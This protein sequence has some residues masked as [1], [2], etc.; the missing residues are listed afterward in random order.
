MSVFGVSFTVYTLVIVAIGI[1]S[2][3]YARRS[4][5]DFF[6]AGRSL[7]PWVAALSASASSESGWVTLGLVGWAFTSGVQA[8]W[9]I[10][11]CLGGF[12]FNWFVVAGRLRVRAAEVGALTLPDFFAFSAGF[13]GLQYQAGVLIGAGIVLV[14]TVL[15][16]FRA[17]CWTDLIQGV[18]MVGTLVVFPLYVLVSFGGYAFI[19]EHAGA[20]EPQLLRVVPAFDGKAWAP[21]FLGFLLGAGALGINLGYPGQ[22]HVLVRFMALADPRQARIGGLISAVWATLVYWGA[23]TIGLMARAMTEADATGAG[24]FAWTRALPADGGET[25]LVLAA[26]NTIPG[27][28]SGLV[29][30]AVLAAICS[31]A[32]SQLVVAASSAANDIYFRLVERRRRLA[33]ILVNRVVMLGLGVAAVLLV[34]DSRIQVY[35]YVL[36]YGWAILGASFGPQL[37]LLLLWKRATYAGCIAGMLTGFLT[38]LLWK[39]LD[40]QQ[41]VEALEVYNLTLAFAAALVVNVVVSLVT[42]RQ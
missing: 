20:A 34:I 24:E 42:R 2:A 12:L 38:A 37:V 21:A 35:K 17:A 16:G 15:G 31:T 8:Y 18:I 32:D 3:R 40:L 36:E 14:Y 28:F 6:L 39:L 11:G 7:G 27:I 5:E 19:G 25:G 29:L 9:I 1:Y 26:Q 4:D 23:V 33:H 30:A 22:P 13:D 10:P 41:Y